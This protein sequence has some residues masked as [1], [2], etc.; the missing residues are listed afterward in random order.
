MTDSASSKFKGAKES[1]VQKFVLDTSALLTLIEA[2]AG[3]E[4]VRDV[5]QQ[6]KTYIPFVAV[7]ELRYIT[8]R[9]RG[10]AEADVRYALLRQLQ[11]EIIWQVDEPTLLIAARLKASYRLSLGDALIAACAKTRGATLLHKDPEYEPLHS[12][13]LLEAL[14]YKLKTG[15]PKD[16]SAKE[17]QAKNHP[18]E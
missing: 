17:S 6:S 13:S 3:A 9:E 2:E 15:T 12:E 1:T 4:R 10:Q 8:L 14:P 11:T 5:L 7:L 16:R 18:R